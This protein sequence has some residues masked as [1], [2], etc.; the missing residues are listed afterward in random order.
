MEKPSK[1]PTDFNGDYQSASDIL[2]DRIYRSFPDNYQARVGSNANSRRDFSDE[3]AAAIDT[4]SAAIAAA[5]RKGAT[6]KQ[7]AA[8]GAASVGI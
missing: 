6:V 4:A 3:R 7:A 2:R 8:A 1:V 5:L